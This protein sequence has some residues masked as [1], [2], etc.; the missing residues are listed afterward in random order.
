MTTA[1]F[2]DDHI[3]LPEVKKQDVLAFSTYLVLAYRAKQ[4]QPFNMFFATGAQIGYDPDAYHDAYKF[5][6]LPETRK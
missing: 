6:L 1:E 2:Y 3:R 4:D 5:Y